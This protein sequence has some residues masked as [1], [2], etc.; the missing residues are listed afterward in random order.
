MLT[1]AANNSLRTMEEHFNPPKKRPPRR[2]KVEGE[3]VVDGSRPRKRRRPPT[4]YFNEQGEPFPGRARALLEGLENLNLPVA[5]AG[6]AP[7]SP[8]EPEPPQ[9]RFPFRPDVRPQAAVA[10]HTMRM[11]SPTMPFPPPAYRE[12]T[13]QKPL[14]ELSIPMPRAHQMMSPGMRSPGMSSPQMMM[15]RSPQVSPRMLSPGQQTAQLSPR[16]KSMT[17]KKH[18][19]LSSMLSPGAQGATSNVSPP[20]GMVSPLNQMVRMPRNV[21]PVS[22]PFPPRPNAQP[23]TQ[24]TPNTPALPSPVARPLFSPQQPGAPQIVPPP[25]APPLASPGQLALQQ[26]ARAQAPL[27]PPASR[28]ERPPVYPVPPQAA[29]QTLQNVPRFQ[30]MISGIPPQRQPV[31]A[32]PPPVNPVAV[33]P[34]ESPVVGSLPQ[35]AVPHTPHGEVLPISQE[36]VAPAVSSAPH[37]DQSSNEETS[38]EPR[39]K[40]QDL[41]KSELLAAAWESRQPKPSVPQPEKVIQKPTIANTISRVEEQ[42]RKVA[43]EAPKSKAAV[44]L[45]LEQVQA[46]KYSSVMSSPVLYRPTVPSD[47]LRMPAARPPMGSTLPPISTLQTKL[48]PGLVPST[49]S[50]PSSSGGQQTHISAGTAVSASTVRP[51]AVSP[52]QPAMPPVNL[53][54]QTTAVVPGQAPGSKGLLSSPL[55]PAVLAKDLVPSGRSLTAVSSTVQQTTP[56]PSTDGMRNASAAPAAVAR[57]PAPFPLAFAPGLPPVGLMMQPLPLGLARPGMLPQVSMN[58]SPGSAGSV[59]SVPQLRGPVG[60][61]PKPAQGPAGNQM[62]PLDLIAEVMKKEAAANP[63]ALLQGQP[64]KDVKPGVLPSSSQAQNEKAASQLRF[65]IPGPTMEMLI[66]IMQREVAAAQIQAQ[67]AAMHAAHAQAQVQEAAGQKAAVSAVRPTLTEAQVAQLQPSAPP[68][69]AAQP[70]PVRAPLP[71]V[72]TVMPVNSWSARPPVS[73]PAASVVAPSHTAPAPAI[74][75][76]SNP[77]QP[78]VLTVIFYGSF[79]WVKLEAS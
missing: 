66:A 7:I 35:Q 74:P 18:P 38:E 41:I 42:L 70:A 29:H 16:S 72:S 1:E 52:L 37:I 31:Q 62:N 60:G 61:H 51:P 12:R 28:P 46:P 43:S 68:A 53:D 69:P 11:Q 15:Q 67:V 32:Q 65:P 73:K 34:S 23:H 2:R 50:M 57:L 71:P 79:H 6:T 77:G 27:L 36:P 25:S 75:A 45:S 48:P 22:F 14:P 9:P 20:C 39:P 78:Q 59:L 47:A 58:G 8:P 55:T 54:K 4:L 63:Q 3:G 10:Q 19:L 17:Q 21:A 26:I 40:I 44:N 49:L 5:T 24:V 33:Q 56:Q 30:Q 13:L 76:A 64:Q